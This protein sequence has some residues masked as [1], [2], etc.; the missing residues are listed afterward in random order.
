MSKKFID[1]TPEERR[2][3]GRKGGIKSGESKRRKKAM[4][5][6]LEVLL[7]M[8]M[9]KGRM[10]DVE[11]IRS[12]ADLK[13]KNISVEAAMMVQMIQKALKGDTNA[14]SFIR[15]TSGQKPQDEVNVTGAIPVVIS[16]E[17]D[18]ED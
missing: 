18:L 4:R 7:D 15:D 5:E 1:M 2:E 12:F 13:G 16:G 17:S 14:A 3:A 8:P 11:D 9:K 10:A 6:T